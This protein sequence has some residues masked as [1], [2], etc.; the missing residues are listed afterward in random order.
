MKR[1]IIPKKHLANILK[2]ITCI[3]FCENINYVPKS[4]AA[5]S[6]LSDDDYAQIDN[7]KL[8]LRLSDDK[9][10]KISDDRLQLIVDGEVLDRLYHLCPDR[11]DEVLIERLRKYYS[12]NTFDVDEAD[13]DYLL[14]LL[15]T[16]TNVVYHRNP[17]K[18]TST[19]EFILDSGDRVRAADCLKVLKSL[20]IDDY[21]EGLIG[22]DAR[23]FG[24]DLIVFRTYQPWTTLSGATIS[25]ICIYIKLD[26][27]MTDGNAV[28]I[29]S[30]HDA[31]YED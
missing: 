15:K 3:E 29:V 25:E 7:D 31:K 21:R 2:A 30:F 6:D 20:T 26:L 12:D 16:C 18:R 8:L 13:I 28:A 5:A 19:D 22:A 4:V 1:L 23:Y 17:R 24:D 11:F 9:L 10:S 14:G 27:N